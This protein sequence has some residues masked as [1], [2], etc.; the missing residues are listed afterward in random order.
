M[1]GSVGFEP[2]FLKNIT[3]IDLNDSIRNVD[4]SAFA[5]CTALTTFIGGNGLTNIGGSAFNG[6]TSLS[7]VTYLG[8]TQPQCSDYS[9]SKCD[10]LHGNICVSVDYNSSSFCSFDVSYNPASV[11]RSEHNH[12]YHTVVCNGR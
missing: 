10:S 6:C 9:F 2:V 3:I 8:L 1:F 7:S 12:C 5:G 11:N 4:S